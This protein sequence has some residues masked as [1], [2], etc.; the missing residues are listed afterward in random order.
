MSE[1]KKRSHS[2]DRDVK[3]K[4]E[5]I[6]KIAKK[7][8]HLEARLERVL[9]QQEEEKIIGSSQKVSSKRDL[10]K[11]D[12]RDVSKK[13]WRDSSK[14]DSRDSSKKDSRDSSKKDSRVSS[15]KVSSRKDGKLA[16][17][18]CPLSRL[19]LRGLCLMI[20]QEILLLVT[21]RT[22]FS[23]RHPVKFLVFSFR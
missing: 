7:M 20:A 14:E 1:S 4:K 9:R 21:G 2:K 3:N 10:S 19:F 13:V 23:T 16:M 5:D 22:R 15:N 17:N 18:I 12:M 8:R 6:Q 11:K